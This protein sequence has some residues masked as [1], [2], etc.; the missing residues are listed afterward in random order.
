MVA[1]GMV[2]GA[3]EE[4]TVAVEA[5]AVGQGEARRTATNHPQTGDCDL[6]IMR[7]QDMRLCISHQCNHFE[8]E[9]RTAHPGWPAHRSDGQAPADGRLLSPQLYQ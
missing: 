9:R 8:G 5:V 3:E 4:T 1:V 7:F 2:W 6:R